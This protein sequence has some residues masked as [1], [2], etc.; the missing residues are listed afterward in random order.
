MMRRFLILATFLY[1]A[2]LFGAAATKV[3]GSGG[4][5]AGGSG[6]TKVQATVSGTPTGNSFTLVASSPQVFGNSSSATYVAGNVGDILIACLGWENTGTITSISSDVEGTMTLTTPDIG[7]AVNSVIATKVCASASA[8]SIT[9]VGSGTLA[10]RD[11]FIVRATTTGTIT[12]GTTAKAHGSGTNVVSSAYTT[13]CVNGLLV[14]IVKPDGST[15]HAATTYGGVGSTDTAITGSASLGTRL[16][17]TSAQTAATFVDNPLGT[18]R[19]WSTS[20][21]TIT[22]Q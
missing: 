13:A 11:W 17:H 15:T 12:V 20:H 8:G 21:V 9:L 1:S 5:K 3:G 7:T 19:N 4:T 18:S 2:S 6:V 16:A 10:F 14:G 22:A